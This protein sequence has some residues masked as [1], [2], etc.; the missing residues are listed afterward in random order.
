M[1][2]HVFH[3]LKDDN[4]TYPIE[5]SLVTDVIKSKSTRDNIVF[6][7]YRTVILSVLEKSLLKINH[8]LFLRRYVNSS[9]L[10]SS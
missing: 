8:T 1:L 3:T 5:S 9:I 2:N 6:S 7:T 10:S 4:G